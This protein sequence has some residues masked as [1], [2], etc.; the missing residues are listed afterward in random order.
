MDPM[1]F[2]SGSPVQEVGF[3]E[4]KSDSEDKEALKYLPCPDDNPK[5]EPKTLSFRTVGLFEE[6]TS[7]EPYKA[8]DQYD[9]EKI[10]VEWMQFFK[11]SQP[12]REEM[13]KL[14]RDAVS[15]GKLTMDELMQKVS[16]VSSHTAVTQ[17]AK[18]QLIQEKTSQIHL[19]LLKVQPVPPEKSF[20]ESSG[21]VTQGLPDVGKIQLN[22]PLTGYLKE[23]DDLKGWVEELKSMGRKQPGYQRRLKQVNEKIEQLVDL[24]RNIRLDVGHYKDIITEVSTILESA[25]DMDV[26]FELK[27]NLESGVSIGDL[28]KEFSYG[29]WI[30]DNLKAFSK[31]VERAILTSSLSFDGVSINNHEDPHCSHKIRPTLVLRYHDGQEFNYL[32]YPFTKVSP[33]GSLTKLSESETKDDHIFD[34]GAITERRAF[35]ESSK[36]KVTT[37]TAIHNGDFRKSKLGIILKDPNGKRIKSVRDL[38]VLDFYEETGL[39]KT[40]HAAWQNYLGQMVNETLDA[41]RGFGL[42]RGRASV[43]RGGDFS[44][45]SGREAALPSSGSRG[46]SF[47]SRSATSDSFTPYAVL[48]KKAEE[49]NNDSK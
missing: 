35:N 33:D 15:E 20:G 18:L 2:L 11:S 41:D 29:S 16:E 36:Y 34:M 38:N 25:R 7:S 17:A 42:T 21:E 31:T 9:A 5:P 13:Q 30:A 45:V 44:K 27:K 6:G 4:G 49:E 8:L 47:G 48:Y 1:S 28:S 39:H 37:T 26:F 12:Q 3:Q 24:G 22:I 32:Y 19:N 40:K 46:F 43:L 10:I 23:I 14:V